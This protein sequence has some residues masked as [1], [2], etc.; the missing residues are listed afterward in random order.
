MLLMSLRERMQRRRVAAM[1][2]IPPQRSTPMT[3]FLQCRRLA[4]CS[5]AYWEE[6]ERDEPAERETDFGKKR[7]GNGEKDG[8][9]PESLVR[10][11]AGRWPGARGNAYRT[12]V[13][14]IM[15]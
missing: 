10:C 4:S 8:V 7:D 13:V 5:A 2:K 9:S 14:A 11:K 3:S 15:M 1:T 12:F 6:G